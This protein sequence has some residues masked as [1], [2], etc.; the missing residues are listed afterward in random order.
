MRRIIAVLALV[1]SV[2]AVRADD[3]RE[4]Y[5]RQYKDV[6]VAQMISSG[7]PASITLAQAC[8]ESGNGTSTLARKANNHFGIKCRNWSGP[9]IRHDDDLKDECFRSYDSAEQSFQDHSDFL[10]YNDRYSSLFDLEITDYEGWAHGLR[11]AGYATDP[12]YAEKLI[13]IIEDYRLYEYDVIRQL[14]GSAEPSPLPPSP[15]ALERP[16]QIEAPLHFKDHSVGHVTIEYTFYE[17]YGLVYILANGTETYA[18]LARQFNLFKRE[19][20][21]FNEE[22]RDHVIPAGTVV[23]LQAK[24]NQ[25]TKDLA[26]HVVERGET[27]KSLSQ[28]FGVK[29]K[30]LY[31][32]NDIAPGREPA[33]GNIINLRKETNEKAE[34]KR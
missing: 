20:L 31:K 14:P 32:Y 7:I 22:K 13:K 3:L 24:R 30:K 2:V 23:Y 19:L 21:R 15:S 8:L 1:L 12:T 10:R 9:T 18:S 34:T 4:K 11:K 6:A 29:M 33:V 28:R 16:R 25:S 26:K 27:M 17:K 5:I